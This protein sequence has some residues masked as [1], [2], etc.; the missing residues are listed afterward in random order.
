MKSGDLPFLDG[1]LWLCQGLALSGRSVSKFSIFRKETSGH[2]AV[3]WSHCR[4]SRGPCRF[5]SEVWA[6]LHFPHSS[7]I[8]SFID[9]G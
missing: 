5:T 2:V 7:T 8:H 6:F 1:P 3:M 4:P 9:I